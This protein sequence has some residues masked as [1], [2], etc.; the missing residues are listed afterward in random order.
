MVARLLTLGLSLAALAIGSRAHAADPIDFAARIQPIFAA[1]CVGCHGAE[2]QMG[3]LR[4]DAADQI[5]AF[6]EKDELLVAAKPE[7]S[8]LFRRITLPADD[9]K[10][11]PKGGDP[12]TAE[13]I[14]LIRQWIASQHGECGETG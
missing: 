13:E 1:R 5:A 6:G 11:M 3:K 8:E 2:Q 12:L 4:L 7:E 10:R 14:E 9:K